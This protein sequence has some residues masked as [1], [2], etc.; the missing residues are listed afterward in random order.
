MSS[1][2]V[3][4]DSLIIRLTPLEKLLG[5]VRDQV[6]P[7]AAVEHV[8]A[9][10]DGLAAASGLRAPGLALPGRRKIGTWRG[11]G[12][13]RFVCVRGGEPALKVTISGSRFDE[14]VVSTPDADSIAA[15]LRG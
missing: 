11:G 8:E 2:T 14:L 12:L 3:R 10:P 9:V 1:V 4:G 5:L 13:K 15:Q 7:R 6:V